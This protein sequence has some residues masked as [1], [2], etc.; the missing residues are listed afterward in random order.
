MRTWGNSFHCGELDRFP[1]L[2]E[3]S[4]EMGGDLDNCDFWYCVMRAVN[5]H[6]RGPESSERIRSKW[7]VRVAP[8]EKYPFHR[9]KE[10]SGF[11]YNGVHTAVNL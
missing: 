6:R 9:A 5:Q 8:I 3:F 1:V 11:Y 10:P 2:E 7:P 4:D